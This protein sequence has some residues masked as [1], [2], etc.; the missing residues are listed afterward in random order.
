M[1]EDG[2]LNLFGFLTNDGANKWDFLGLAHPDWPQWH[3]PIPWDNQTFQHHN[4]DLTLC[5]E[6]NLRTDQH[7]LWLEGHNGRHSIPYQSEVQR[8]MDVAWD[9]LSIKNKAN[10]RMALDK[11][12]KGISEDI[13]SEKLMLYPDKVVRPANPKVYGKY[14]QLSGLKMPRGAGNAYS[15]VID[16]ISILPG[17]M[18]EADYIGE[19][20]GEGMS[21]PQAVNDL[22]NFYDRVQ[23]EV[24]S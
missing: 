24:S 10:A 5:A 7:K 14:K 19:K 2:G 11:V 13:N 3:H 16:I 9:N 20:M 4:H 6:V 1:E 18:F 22:L 17:A 23:Y 8:R 15:I 12:V 21:F